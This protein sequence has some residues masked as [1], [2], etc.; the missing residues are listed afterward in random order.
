MLMAGRA[1]PIIFCDWGCHYGFTFHHQSN[2]NKNGFIEYTITMLILSAIESIDNH[3][4]NQLVHSW[5]FCV[6]T[7]V[8]LVHLKCV[9]YIHYMNAIHF[10]GGN[11]AERLKK[12]LQ[13]HY[14]QHLKYETA[15][16]FQQP[17]FNSP[18]LPLKYHIIRWRRGRSPFANE[19]TFLLWFRANSLLFILPAQTVNANNRQCIH[20]HTHTRNFSANAFARSQVSRYTTSHSTG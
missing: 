8:T 6:W 11:V 1:K 17:T 15:L 19:I 14:C 12:R 7:A 9:Q 13:H 10:G 18:Q 2:N 5:I 4:Y 20:T 16:T 3:K